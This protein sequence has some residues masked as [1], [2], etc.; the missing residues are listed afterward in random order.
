MA[1]NFK[2]LQPLLN[3]IVVQKPD[4]SKVSKGGIILKATTSAQWGTVV[5]VGPGRVMENGETRAVS[6][7]V[8]D[9]VLLPEYGGHS[10]KIGADQQELHVYRDDDIIGILEE[11][12]AQ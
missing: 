4:A 7:K 10:I 6:L 5:A 1:L 9:D 8:G 2:K 12:L 11:K 3:R